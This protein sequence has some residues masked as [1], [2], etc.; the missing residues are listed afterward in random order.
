MFY[1]DFGMKDYSGMING[2]NA[3]RYCT[4][5]FRDKTVCIIELRLP[6]TGLIALTCIFRQVGGKWAGIHWLI[7]IKNLCISLR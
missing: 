5:K 2:I 6:V 7:R 4:D 3:K 1:T